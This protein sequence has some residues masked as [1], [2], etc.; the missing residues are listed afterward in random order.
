M[1]PLKPVI[2]ETER[3]LLCPW[4][5]EDKAPFADL[6]ADPLVMRY[7]PTVLSREESDR[8]A[9]RFQKE[10]EE[11]GWGLFAAHLKK[12]SEFIG[13]IGLS[14]VHFEA[15]FTPAIEIGWRLALP[16]WKQGF[17]TE[18]AKKCVEF[19]FETLHE[20][21]LVSFTAKDNA[22]SIKVMERLGMTRDPKDDFEHPKLPLGHPL[23][24][25]LLY[26]LHR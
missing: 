13:Y 9:D 6:N 4:K 24:P 3:L 2:L 26:R 12:T 19:A 11:R 7:F 23:R 21:Q 17:A 20:K 15:H 1:K 25:H 16:F 22:R 8:L 10:I 5:E 18:G 14:P